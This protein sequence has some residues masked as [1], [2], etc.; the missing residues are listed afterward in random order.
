M[1]SA[2][3]LL[4]FENLALSGNQRSSQKRPS[5]AL[6]IG[7]WQI[8]LG[9]H[10]AVVGGTDQ[11]RSALTELIRS[12]AQQQLAKF[13]EI[14]P[15]LQ[16]QLVLQELERAKTGFSDE[17]FTGTQVK[18]FL[19]PTSD[20][21]FDAGELTEALIERTDLRS[22]LPKSL[23]ALS[24]GE[25]RRV[26]S[27]KAMASNAA[28]YLLQDPFEGLDIS[29]K[30]T[31]TT[32][33]QEQFGLP[34]P[35]PISA[36]SSAPSSTKTSIFVASRWKDIPH[37][38]TAL[39]VIEDN[40]LHCLCTCAQDLE[41]ALAEYRKRIEKKQ[42]FKL[43]DLPEGHPYH[44]RKAKNSDQLVALKQVTVSY[45][46]QP[47]PVF[48]N[49]DFTVEPLQ[50]T[51]I[52][53]KNGCG[54]S[55]LLKIIAGD[56]P[57]VYNNDVS[58]CGFK[59][60]RGESV[61]DV[62]RQIGHVSGETLWHYRGS[63]FSVGTTRDVLV[64]GLYDSI[65][66]Y[67]KPNQAD[68]ICAQQWLDLFS[69]SDRTNVSFRELSMA[70]Q[71]LALVA[72]AMIKR[73]ALLLLDEPCA[74]LDHNDRQRVIEIIELLITKNASTILYVSHREDEAIT[75]IQRQFDVEAYAS[76]Q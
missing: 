16:E 54:K 7:R 14:S 51:R 56:H 10:W 62:K 2:S 32:I 71:R 27:V 40:R 64:S 74:N 35:V 41:S 20:S 21:S 50:H 75:G 72:R 1:N 26:I 60:G 37:Y 45:S 23:R 70:E 46:D 24:S 31:L 48:E 73:P 66:Q 67:H 59:R 63:T 28:L 36:S 9:E 30:K 5:N 53:G 3:L 17:I 69:L 19:L 13:A 52:V 34:Q 22:C 39:A 12:S 58:I 61:W 65:G 68:I 11:Q 18:D 44:Q 8:H 47:R 29:G 43:P 57:Q 6:Q 76:A 4:N 15:W 42:L 33:F 49:L 55:T 25:T 38:S